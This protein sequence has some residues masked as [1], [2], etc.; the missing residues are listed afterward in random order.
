MPRVLFQ[1]VHHPHPEHV[2]DLLGAMGRIA[3][4]APGVAGL[5]EIGAFLDADTGRVLAIT[6]WASREA[7]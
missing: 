2:D 4:A 5:D 7:M 1:V 3:E 6:V